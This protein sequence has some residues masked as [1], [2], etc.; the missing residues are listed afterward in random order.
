MRITFKENI[1]SG[2]L[3]TF[4]G[5]DGSGKTTMIGL[6]EKY[7]L[8]KGRKCVLVKQPSEEIRSN[9]LFR[10]SID[11]PYSEKID[12]RAVT[13]LC[14][15]D[16]LQHSSKV[17]EPLLKD[18]YIVI[19][20]RYLFSSIANL[21]ACGLNNEKWIYEISRHIVKPDVAFFINVKPQTATN[22]VK[23]RKNEKNR[24]IDFEL[25]RTLTTV[26]SQL[27][28]TNNGY[29]IDCEISIQKSFENIQRIV[30][31]VIF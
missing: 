29:T 24:F 11:Q 28:A 18:G 8:A 14:V 23:S 1:Y 17:I 27:A 5:L 20:D 13:M 9:F 19:S 12:Y 10:A 25:Q 31:G 3:I 15:A 30:N 2:K 21:E 16:K 7:L 26:Y 4:C 22:R 6:L